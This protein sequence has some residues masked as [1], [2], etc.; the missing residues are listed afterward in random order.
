M[1][2]RESFGGEFWNEIEKHWE[3]NDP[4]LQFTGNIGGGR[5]G[6]DRF[7][8]GYSRL[9]WFDL[10]AKRGEENVKR[11]YWGYLWDLHD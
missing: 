7:I 3:E 11:R 6:I 5:K 4:L 10:Y 9:F 1:G 2:K 8:T